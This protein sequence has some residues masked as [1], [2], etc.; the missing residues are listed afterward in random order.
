MSPPSTP[1]SWHHVMEMSPPSTP[2]CRAK[3]NPEMSPPSTPQCRV[4]TNPVTP[5]TCVPSPS[6]L[7]EEFPDA[8]DPVQTL[9]MPKMEGLPKMPR[10][11]RMDEEILDVFG[12]LP[13]TCSNAQQPF[14][15]NPGRFIN[16]W[17]PTTPRRSLGQ[18]QL[19]LKTPPPA[20]KHRISKSQMDK[21]LQENDFVEVV[22]ILAKNP[23][24]ANMPFFDDSD[25]FPLGRALRLQCDPMIIQC[26]EDHGAKIH[27]LGPEDAGNWAQNWHDNS[28]PPFV[29]ADI[30]PLSFND[31]MMGA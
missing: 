4:K 3:T 25:E 26:L 6:P 15:Q 17:W 11:P 31:M 13:T 9:F 24:V 29:G 5:S 22:D 1:R 18:Q 7:Q 14:I 8:L 23:R 2:Q 20:P 28:L 19:H 12:I 27:G 10:M 21:A 30:C 16:E